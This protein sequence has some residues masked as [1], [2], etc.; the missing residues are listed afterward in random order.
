MK[1]KQGPAC[2]KTKLFAACQGNQER[3]DQDMSTIPAVPTSY[4]TGDQYKSDANKAWESE[5]NTLD[6]LPNAF[7]QLIYIMF[8]MMPTKEKEVG[9]R[10]TRNSRRSLRP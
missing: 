10:A 3:K 6:T 9:E 1:G 8:V 5:L 2:G 4:T 7:A